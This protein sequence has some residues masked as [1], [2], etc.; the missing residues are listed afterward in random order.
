M[1]SGSISSR[2]PESGN[3]CSGIAFLG[4]SHSQ[5]PVRRSGFGLNPQRM[6]KLR[7][8]LLEL[9]AI[10]RFFALAE[11]Q[12]EVLRALVSRHKLTALLNFRQG[13]VFTTRA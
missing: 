5:Q 12:T 11:I 13:F 1:S 7:N 4:Q 6:A 2:F 3:T 9:T 8:R 10:E